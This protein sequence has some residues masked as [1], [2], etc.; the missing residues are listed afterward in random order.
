MIRLGAT[1]TESHMDLCRELEKIFQRQGLDFDWVLYSGYG[2]MEDAFVRKEIDLAWNGPLS[3][4]RTKRALNN[5][6]QNLAMRD[7]DIDFTTHFITQAD[8]DITTVEDLHRKRF[9]LG[10]RNSV[11]AGLLA[12]KYLK[13]SGIDPLLD[14]A[15]C[16]YHEDRP[17]TNLSDEQDVI[18]QIRQCDYYAGAVS[19]RTL[20]ILEKQGTLAEAR[21]QV[22]W[23]SPGYSHCC[24]TAHSGLDA[25]TAGEVTDAFLSVDPG[26][27]PGKAVLE[28]E[29]CHALVPG[30]NEGWEFLEQVA[31]QEELI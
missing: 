11:Q 18:E 13:Q 2:A 24:F 6:C 7:V 20:E 8:S 30:I 22:F 16:T 28:A 4:L 5:A 31:E 1:A 14:L 23:S 26:D 19:K 15:A 9:A 10:S 3:Y 25:E 12:Y 27:A 17:A 21:I 29:D